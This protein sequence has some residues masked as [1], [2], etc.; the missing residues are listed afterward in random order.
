MP[1]F[2]KL[3]SILAISL[4]LASCLAQ[5]EDEGQSKCAESPPGM[6]KLAQYPALY[7]F[8]FEND[9]FYGTDSDYTNGVKFSWV[10]ANLKDYTHD[11][12]LPLWVRQLNQYFGTV[13]PGGY[14][15]RNMVVTAG[16]S[17]FTPRDGKR[18][19]LILNDR[20]YAGWLY[21]GLGYNARNMRQMDTVEF[22][23]G[24]VGPAA[25]ARQN[26]NLIHDMR[27]FPRLNGW[28]NQLRN[29]PGIQVV[30]ERRKRVW[31]SGESAGPKFDT[32]THYGASLGNVGTYLNAGLEMRIGNRL[33][34]DFGTSPI[35][36]AG[37][38]NAPLEGPV[39]HRFSDG[40]LQAF[41]SADARL[42]ARNIFLD[43]NTFVASHHVAKKLFVGDVAAGVAWQWPGGKITY[44]HYVRSKEFE[45]QGAAHNYGSITFSIEY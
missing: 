44:A 23:V 37:D 9:L 35:R 36:P 12:C 31:D 24:I 22:N 13:H 39:T 38:S 11:P 7:N 30:A 17:M 29:E 3:H 8:H 43:G 32:I 33:P 42:V 34:N 4:A 6:A 20:P 2:L 19:D 5:A 21:L 41:I 1:P 10:S 14:T 45:G 25:L 28:G 16:Q 26:Q 15:T 27:G 40:G 18:T